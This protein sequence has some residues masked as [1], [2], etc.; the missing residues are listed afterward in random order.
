MLRG[1]IFEPWGIP[2]TLH[3]RYTSVIN[4]VR[5]CVRG[6]RERKAQAKEEADRTRERTA[7]A[8]AAKKLAA[9]VGAGA[10]FKMAVGLNSP[11]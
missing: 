1:K 11:V 3:R 10:S 5:L 2:H 4:H 7:K 9:T 8:A 6:I